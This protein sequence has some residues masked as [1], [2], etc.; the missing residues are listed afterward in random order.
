MRYTHFE[1]KNFKGIRS[2][3]L[4]LNTTPRGKIHTLV[5][6]NESGKTTILEAIDYFIPSDEAL[7]PKNL[8]GRIR[9][10]QH[11]LIPVA[12]RANFNG[13]TTISAGFELDDSD[14][15]ALKKYM[16]TEYGYTLGTISNQITITD[17]YE[18]KNSK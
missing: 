18:F 11:D 14:I 13:E 16:R 8:G 10:D 3:R 1:I 15:R 4:D 5:G 9:Q 2:L 17:K 6:L 7:D 12:S